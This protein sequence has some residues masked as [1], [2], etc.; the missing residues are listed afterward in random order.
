MHVTQQ[1]LPFFEAL[2]S[3][4]RLQIVEQ[5]GEGNMNIR[6]LAERLDLS[7]S[8]VARHVRILEDANI[9]R[10]QQ[11]PARRGMQKLCRLVQSGF[12]LEFPRAHPFPKI[13]TLEIP[14]GSYVDWDVTPTC[15]LNTQLGSVGYEDDVR[16]FSDP[17]RF[18]AAVVWFGHGYLEYAIPNYLTRSERLDEIRVQAEICSEAPGYAMDWPSD[19]FFSMN[20][21]E[22]GRWTCPGC[23]GDRKGIYTP[24]WVDVGSNS[25]YGDL[26]QLVVDGNGSYINGRKISDVNVRDIGAAAQKD[27]RLLLSSPADAQNPGGLTIFGRGYGDFDQHI[28][29][30]T[31]ASDNQV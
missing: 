20:G 10:T 24:D 28:L 13:N 14:V 30:T 8:I 7:E 16:V 5:L 9:I 17:Q 6:E 21:L 18:S 27:F 22:L 31:V 11:V 12:V 23:Y 2:A 15:G 25:Q 4:T 1:A 26:I 29:F 19:I 3:G